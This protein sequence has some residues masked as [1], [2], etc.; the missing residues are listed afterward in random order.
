MSFTIRW[1]INIKKVGHSSETVF[2]L[3]KLLSVEEVITCIYTIGWTE[4]T[5]KLNLSGS[6]VRNV[7][8]LNNTFAQVDYDW[9]V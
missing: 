5:A 6:F 2:L 7:I 3:F 1:Q 8:Y 4:L 9:E